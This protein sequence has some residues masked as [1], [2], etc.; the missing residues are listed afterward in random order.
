MRRCGLLT[1]VATLFIAAP[2]AAQVD[3][4]GEWGPLYHEDRPERMPG[5]ELGDYMGLPISDAARRAADSWD[6]DRIS[7]VTQYQCR[8]HS[9][10]YGM[11]GLGNLRVWREINPANQQ[12]T[13]FHTYMPAWG[14]ERTIWM[15]GRPHPGPNAPHT[16]MGFSTGHYEGD[17]LVIE[18]RNYKRWSLDDYY[19]QNPKEY[20]MHSE[21][22]HSIERL[23]RV[24]ADT[25]AYEFTV[26]DPKIFTKPWSVQWE[27]KRHPEW[28]KTG[29]YEMVC[30]E[31]NRCEGGKCRDSK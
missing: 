7:V 25:I 11:R 4:T 24:D 18:A 21:A 2:A 14:S 28:E 30:N 9:S 5:P 17:M 3:F 26:D 27:M 6:A 10:D 13:A 31:N 8:P 23:R 16:W 1:I 12:L 15:D 20:R 19:Y 22:F 29:L